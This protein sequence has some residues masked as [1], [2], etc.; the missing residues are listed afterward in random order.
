[1]YYWIVAVTPNK[2]IS[3]GTIGKRTRRVLP[4]DRFDF[5]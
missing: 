5:D 2:W 4:P 1:M 3:E